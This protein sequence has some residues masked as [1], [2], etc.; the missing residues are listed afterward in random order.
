MY[1]AE[2]FATLELPFESKAG[3]AY[4]VG[5]EKSSFPN[6]ISCRIGDSVTD[7]WAG[8]SRTRCNDLDAYVDVLPAHAACEDEDAWVR[9]QQMPGDLGGDRQRLGKCNAFRDLR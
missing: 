8:S 6:E 1:A 2:A 4:V 3:R 5:C 7:E 9:L